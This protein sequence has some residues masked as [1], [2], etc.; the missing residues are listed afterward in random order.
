MDS[1]YVTEPL[2]DALYTNDVRSRLG[3]QDA[4]CR[5]LDYYAKVEHADFLN[6]MLYLDA[7]AFMVSL[8]LTYNDKMSMANS[9][10]VRVPFV[11][12]ELAHWVAWNVP[13]GLK[14]RRGTTKYIFREAMRE[15]LPPEVLRQKK[16]G[17]GAPIDY[18]LAGG[19]R[20][21]TD[22]LLS[23]DRIARRGLRVIF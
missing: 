17:L 8:N 18:W 10:E 13:P 23:E 14:L 6:R 3:N 19:L 22:D 21:L 4:R 9:V 5:H 16:A 12:P 2:K 1:I 15:L 7:K 20:E 11:D